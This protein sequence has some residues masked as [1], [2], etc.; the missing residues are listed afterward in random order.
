MQSNRKDKWTFRID[1]GMSWKDCPFTIFYLNGAK[2]FTS[3]G[4]CKESAYDR[5]VSLMSGTEEPP[6]RDPTF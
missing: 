5:C 2:Y 6:E 3:L 1:Y 4:G